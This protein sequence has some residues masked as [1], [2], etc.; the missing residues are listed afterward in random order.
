MKTASIGSLP[1]RVLTPETIVGSAFLGI[2]ALLMIPV[3]SPALDLL[4]ALSIAI[5]AVVFLTALFSER[6]TDFSIFPTLLLISTLLR[7]SLNIA[8]TRL[9]LN[10][11]HEGSEAAGR[12]IY[13][14]SNFVVGGNL[15]VGVIVFLALVL[16]NFV[17]ITKGAGR[18]A[19]VAARFTLDA[20]PGKQ[21]AIDAEL[22]AGSINETEARR[23]REAVEQQA[24]FYGAMDGANKFIRGDAIAGLIITAINL[25]GGLFIG[26]F[27]HGL[28]LAEAAAS[29]SSL[30]IGD[31][32]VSQMPALVVS[33]A[34]GLAISRAS[35]K[36]DFGR[37]VVE[38]MLGMRSVL[39][40]AAVFLLMIGA[41]PGL[42]LFP[43]AVLAATLVFV[44]YRQAGARAEPEEEEKTE[45][46]PEKTEREIQADALRLEPIKLEVGFGLI[47]MADANKGGEIPAKIKNLRRQLAQ[48]LGI[49]VPKV[50][51]ADSMQLSQHEYAISLSG[52]QVARGEI[53]PGRLMA[54][55]AD[56]NIRVDDSI[57]GRDPVFGTP[58]VW[59][60]P[61]AKRRAEAQGAM[62]VEPAS[63]LTTHL[64]EILKRNADA[65]LSRDTVEDLV[66]FVRD[67]APRLVAELLP[68][69]ISYAELS[70]V[71]RLLLE[72]SVSVRDLRSILETISLNINRTKRPEDLADLCRV[73]L[74]RQISAQVAQRDGVIRVLMLDRE[75]EEE[76]LRSL[77]PNGELIPRIG[78]GNSIL[79]NLS[80]QIAETTDRDF[81]NI[82]VSPRLRRPF[83][84]FVRAYQPNIAVVTAVELQSSGRDV[85][86]VG[87]VA[88]S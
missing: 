84:R 62:V 78:L 47:P 35:G 7:L 17:V 81:P 73:A 2:V 4:L 42:P 68:A 85:R 15:A 25:I 46:P 37:Q 63:I 72:E 77:G 50:R 11:G 61:G 48:S 65:L 70:T 40:M 55:K 23:R 1:A 32:L 56:G 51:I 3:P 59:I 6:P 18:I 80:T 83:A 69:Q 31:G 38:Q 82:L 60:Q 67:E 39:G 24:D 27:Q 28:S 53:V 44:A 8:S 16:I 30:T 86:I 75:L 45:A 20:L 76:L 49:I 74:G 54:M 10:S 57:E 19:E 13:A 87:S 52:A 71:L 12:I 26:L 88:A 66:D 33:T 29:Y 79:Q 5:S 58:A 36:S 9:I 22:S 64:S 34:A 14:F 21:M 41:L 43:F